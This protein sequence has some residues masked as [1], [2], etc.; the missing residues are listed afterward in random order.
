MANFDL[1]KRTVVKSMFQTKEHDKL[2]LAV[3]DSGVGIT[4]E[5]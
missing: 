5:D 2:V 3:L 4:K 1:E